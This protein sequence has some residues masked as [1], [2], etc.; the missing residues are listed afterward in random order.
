MNLKKGNTIKADGRS[1]ISP[2]TLCKYML[3][4]INMPDVASFDFRSPAKL[5][6]EKNEDVSIMS[7]KRLGSKIGS[8][9]CLKALKC[10]KKP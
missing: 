7:L 5:W 3:I 9:K 2:E 1:S 10:K 4:T 8:R 6:L